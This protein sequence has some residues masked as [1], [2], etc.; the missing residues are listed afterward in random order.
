MF[1][2]GEIEV[3]SQAAPTDW[4]RPPKLDARL[5]IQIVRK[6]SCLKGAS[7]ELRW[8]TSSSLLSLIVV[9]K[10]FYPCYRPEDAK[11]HPLKLTLLSKIVVCE[12]IGAFGAHG[13]MPCNLRR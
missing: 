10:R 2:E 4:M 1:A 13:P 6:M 5:A 8:G 7:G 12:R 11:C 3:I 9:S